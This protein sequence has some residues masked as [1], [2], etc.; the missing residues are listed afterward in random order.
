MV[1]SAIFVTDAKGKV[2]HSPR[3]GA[4]PRACFFLPRCRRRLLPPRRALLWWAGVL[5]AAAAAAALAAVAAS[6]YGVPRPP[7]GAQVLAG[8]CRASRACP[9]HAPCAAMA[10]AA[11]AR[12]HACLAQR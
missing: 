1:C 9:P 11:A 3:P 4:A 12:L 8:C 6:M 2:R 5:A 7:P 10:T